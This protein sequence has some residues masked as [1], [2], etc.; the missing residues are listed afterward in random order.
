[1]LDF[2]IDEE[3]CVGC[4]LCARGCPVNT[5]FKRDGLKKYYIV[6][7]DCIRCGAC[8]DACKFDAVL[9]TSEGIRAK[10]AVPPRAQPSSPRDTQHAVK[11]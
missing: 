2:R 7:E 11:K 8:F 4:S 1:L 10:M 6:A 3:K 9:K 5:I